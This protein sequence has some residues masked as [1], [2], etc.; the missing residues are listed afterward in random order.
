[1]KRFALIGLIILSLAG[2]GGGDSTESSTLSKAEFRK[3]CLEWREGSRLS[4]ATRFAWKIMRGQCKEIG[5][6]GDG[7][8][9]NFPQSTASPTQRRT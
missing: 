6:S 7:P 8:C 2:C 1:M 4:H 9:S 3:Q 5:V